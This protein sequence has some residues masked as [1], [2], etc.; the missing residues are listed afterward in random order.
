[1]SGYDG[2]VDV[3][4]RLSVTNGPV[5]QEHLEFESN[6][7]TALREIANQLF[8]DVDE[9]RDL[10]V[11][12]ALVKREDLSVDV[13]GNPYH[14]VTELIYSKYETEDKEIFIQL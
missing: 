7:V 12:G 9:V 8:D 3:T 5:V 11:N 1:M 4:V 10:W 2:D 14:V 13:D 6:S